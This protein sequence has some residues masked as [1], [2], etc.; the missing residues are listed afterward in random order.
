MCYNIAY[1]EKRLDVLA[2][3]YAT[4]APSN[5]QFVAPVFH[6]SA[7]SFP[8]WPILTMEEPDSFRFYKW[9]L[10]P[11]FVKNLEQ[12]LKL[13]TMTPNCIG[14]E[15]FDKPS[16]RIPIRNHRC[17]VPV[18]GFFE[19]QTVNKLKYPYFIYNTNH[20]IISLAGVYDSWLDTSSG[21]IYNSFS[22]VTC[23]A[24]SLLTKIHNIK[25]RMPLILNDDQVKTWLNPN[26]TQEVVLSLVQP[27]NGIDLNAHTISKLITDKSKNANSKEV[28]KPFVYE[29]LV[30]NDSTN[31]FT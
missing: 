6:A 25:K 1:I 5:S 27:Y 3:R 24:N 7:F 14:E 28:I 31:L 8:I 30:K 9:G 26:T 29:E 20:E 22:I 16:F 11:F 12:A 21:E 15:A 17:I 23:P 13:R 18:S 4:K 2:K 19:W 10:V